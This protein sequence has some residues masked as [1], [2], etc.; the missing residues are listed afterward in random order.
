MEEISNLY[1]IIIETEKDFNGLPIFVRPFIKG[2]FE[3]K[4][5]M[6]LEQWKASVS[7]INKLYDNYD[8]SKSHIIKTK[9]DFIKPRLEKLVIYIQGVPDMAKK[10]VKDISEMEKIKQTAEYRKQIVLK[11]IEKIRG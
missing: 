7:E 2:E 6:T 5:G 9:L 1:K 3:S 11:V 8:E 4:T 10:F